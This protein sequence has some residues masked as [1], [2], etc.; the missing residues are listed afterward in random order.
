M[1]D[2]AAEKSVHSQ[3]HVVITSHVRVCT[4]QC[5]ISIDMNGSTLLHTSYF[6]LDLTLATMSRKLDE[7]TRSSP[8]DVHI[9]NNDGRVLGV[10]TLRNSLTII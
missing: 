1:D 10:S 9:Y 5:I 4:K 2:G 3:A 8:R 7:P 6:T